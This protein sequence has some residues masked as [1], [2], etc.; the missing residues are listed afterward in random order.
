MAANANGLTAEIRSLLFPDTVP[1]SG[2]FRIMLGYFMA[3][4]ELLN[5]TTLIG[6]L[7]ATEANLRGFHVQE[8]LFP[9]G[10]KAFSVD[11]PFSN[12]AVLRSVRL[13]CLGRRMSFWSLLICL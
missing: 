6:V 2:M 8:H 12:P 1:N 11:V 4:V 5:L 9:N 7:S 10:S 13:R 3:D